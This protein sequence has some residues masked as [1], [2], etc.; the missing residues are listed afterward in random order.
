[1]ADEEK[2]GLEKAL[3]EAKSYIPTLEKV[4]EEIL[5]LDEASHKLVKTFGQGAEFINSIKIGLVEAYPELRRLGY[6]Q[7]DI[8]NMQIN[9]AKAMNTNLIMSKDVQ[10]SLGTAAKISN[11]ESEDLALNFKNAGFNLIQVGEKTTDAVNIARSLG[12]NAEKVTSNVVDNLDKLNQFG[13]NGGVEGLSRMASTA[14]SLR[15]DMN[16]TLVLAED[17]FSPEK[18]IEKAAS[19]QRLGVAQSSLLDPLK[20]MDLAQNDPEELQKQIVEMT[21]S[22]A[23]FNETTGKFEIPK[24]SMRQLKDIGAEL[25]YQYKDISKLTIA[26]AEFD[27][28]LSNINPNLNVDEDT[29]KLIANMS[30]MGKEGNYTIK[31]TEGMETRDIAINDLNDAQLEILKEMSKPKTGEE[32]A[33]EQQNAVQSIKNSVEAIRGKI[34]KGIA[35][36]VPATDVLQIA[37]QLG[38][39]FYTGLKDVL[40]S[41]NVAASS[42]KMITEGT[43]AVIK[44]FQGDMKGVSN[45]MN[46]IADIIKLGFVDNVKTGAEGFAKAGEDFKTLM[47]NLKVKY[48][49]TNDKPNTPPKT[50]TPP[51]TVKA[52]Q[53]DFVYNRKQNQITPID[54]NDNLH[55]FKDMSAFKNGGKSNNLISKLD[56]NHNINLNI[57]GL[58]SNVDTQQVIK[59]VKDSL[60]SIDMQQTLV[61]ALNTTNSE[62]G[63]S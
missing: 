26:A 27:E 52:A 5:N 61:N 10:I 21:K 8:L 39:G 55:G 56:L 62:Y 46:N 47:Q 36:S 15:I 49:V 1:M 53:N 3:D 31:I 37:R 60:N 28:K 25:N 13:F 44:I 48:G 4:N 23:T 6:A 38:D 9:V 32:L 19:L 43:G 51:P 20:L 14:A 18:A 41:E 22:F 7:E 45:K 17:L 12:V 33:K 35:A 54:E 58:P 57:N 40:R 34:E 24:G 42:G 11:Q 29:K 30:E 63:L 59:I 2:S 50:N 16:K